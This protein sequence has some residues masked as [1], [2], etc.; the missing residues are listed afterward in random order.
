[1][2]E[3]PK[4]FSA[5]DLAGDGQGGRSKHGLTTMHL[6]VISVKL[7]GLREAGK[8]PRLITEGSQ[9]SLGSGPMFESRSFVQSGLYRMRCRSRDRLKTITQEAAILIKG[10]QTA[11]VF[12]RLQGC[13]SIESERRGRFVP[14]FGICSGGGRASGT[15]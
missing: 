10:L 5:D 2:Q 7:G 14:V 3:R 13:R 12:R 4:G 11:S 15:H 8:G 6:A 9:Q 1:M